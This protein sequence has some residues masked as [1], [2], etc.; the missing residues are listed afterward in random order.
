MMIALRVANPFQWVNFVV[1]SVNPLDSNESSS[2][3]K[4]KIDRR[5]LF[6]DTFLDYLEAEGVEHIFGIPGGLLHPFFARVE[7]DDRFKIIVT[8]HEQGAAFMADGVARTTN[9]LAVCA[10][11]S[12]P[13]ATNM[14]TGIA[15]SYS[16][17]VPLLVI[18]GQ[19]SSDNIGRGAVQETGREDIDIVSMLKPITKYSAMVTSPATLHHHLRR[20]IRAAMT[21]RKGPVHLN[22]PVNFWS[23][24]TEED[25]YIYEPEKWRPTIELFDRIA[26]QRATDAL[27]E[28]KR[29]VFIAGAGVRRSEAE[30]ELLRLAEY[31][32]ARVV[33]SPTGKGGFPEDHEQSFGVLGVGGHDRAKDLVY[34]RSSDLVFAI[35]TSLSETTTF[36]WDQGLVDEKTFMH[37]D[38]DIKRIGRNYP[39]DI[40]LAG[41]AKTILN[42]IYFHMKRKRDL[43]CNSHAWTDCDTDNYLNQGNKETA[44]GLKRASSRHAL[45]QPRAWRKIFNE[46]VPE[47]SVVFSDVGGHM[48]H[49]IHHLKIGS[50]QDFILNMSFGSMGHGIVAPIGAAMVTG[51]PIIS[52]AGDACFLMNGME[53]VTA[54]EYEIPVLWIIENNQMHGITKHGSELVDKGRAMKCI[55]YKKNV[56]ICT[57][58]KAFG[59]KSIKATNESQFREALE[60]GIKV[61]SNDKDPF[62]IE[63][64]V[65]PDAAPPLLARAA[66]VGGFNRRK[67]F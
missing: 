47:N 61:V 24:D 19:A 4:I 64:C 7:Q 39:V 53:L 45:L 43:G 35:G 25:N 31:T 32:G 5:P 44:G 67:E 62:V 33:T 65:D 20:A 38:I 9:R 40:A 23:I 18:T 13:G 63:V 15:V 29:P 6:I 42:E 14:I 21:G 46:T 27:C 52:I 51:K 37:L 10:G 16:D 8:K 54:S 48:L 60:L 36:N 28:A 17:G 41:D 34:G 30:S 1:Q 50:R 55:Q 2:L 59:L 66:V 26:V 12:G 11:T 3:K 49:N 56:S 57:I 58:S 22:I